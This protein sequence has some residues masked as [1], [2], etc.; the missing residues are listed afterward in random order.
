M[1]SSV[2]KTSKLESLS[3]ILRQE[4]ADGFQDT[5][6][7]GGLDKFLQLGA[8]ELEPVLGKLGSYSILTPPQRETWANDAMRHLTDDAPS[9]TAAN[10]RPPSRSPTKTPPRRSASKP[11]APK[12]SLEDDLTRIRGVT[13]SNLPKL[14]RLGV[15]TVKDLVYLFPHR[16][17]DFA[18]MRKVFELTPGEE[19]TAVLTVWEASETGQGPRKKSTQAI[20]GDDTGNVR[21][22]WYNQPWLARTLRPGTQVVLSGKVGIFRGQFVFESPD[23][24]IFQGQ[25]ELV[26]TG[27]LVPIYPLTDGLYQRTLRRIVKQALDACI[28]K[29][30]DFLPDD[31][32]HRTGLIGIQN[33]IAQ[34]HYPD[35]QHDWDTA[36]RRLAF[37]ELFLMQLAVL[38]RKRE[39]QERGEGIPLSVDAEMID[40]FLD[41]LPY[42]LTNAQS[43]SLKEILN[44]LKSSKPMSRLLQGDV[45]SGKTVVAVVALLAAAF[46]G[47]QGALMAPTEILAEQHFISIPRL[48]SSVAETSRDDH[49]VSVQVEPLSRPLTI[50]LLLGSLPKRV[51]DDMHKRIAEGEVDIIIGTQALIQGAVEIPKLALVVVDEQ[52]RFGVMQRA[53]L[54]E[55]GLRP[56]LLAMS[57]TP[58]PRSLALTVYGDLDVSVID[59]LPPGRQSIRTRWIEP[60]RRQAA[61]GF[62]RK[63]VEEGRQAF[64]VFPLIDES[65]AIHSRAATVEHERLSTQVFPDLKLGLLHGRMALREKE[66]VMELFQR[67]DLDILVSTSVVEVGIDVP[68]ASVMLIDG[69][70][71]FGMAQLHQF[72]G[73]VGRGQHQSYCLLLADSPG[74]EARERLKLVARISDGFQL[75]EEDLRLRG[76]GDYLGTRQSGLPDLRVA[77][78][79]DQ[80]ILS[81]ARREAM[82]LLESDPSL[83]KEENAALAE[84]YGRYAAGLADDV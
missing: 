8:D 31:L 36:R 11:S 19:Q 18:N 44:D 13:K 39:W 41:S 81:L 7:M 69:A 30:T 22:I 2:S 9:N 1:A 3:K 65:E 59:E 70:D 57:A 68:N 74:L 40:T 67:G 28:S 64:I 53:S 63:Q 17:N 21:A 73:R 10:N 76:P 23:Y 15:E 33:A 37:D 51:K 16:H 60:E 43:T 80:E 71:R 14:K 24:D 54:R 6:V 84:H 77:R 46:D 52:H 42:S 29:V 25:E 55:K 72:R 50:G 32:R 47:Y 26:N 4:K 58:I 27:R 79:T 83:S 38:T 78:I 35:S 20:L 62:V 5:T 82:R 66:Q 34:M 56:H 48:L 45:G 75:A 12:L 49:L 61:Y